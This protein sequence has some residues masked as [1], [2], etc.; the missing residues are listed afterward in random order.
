MAEKKYWRC[1]ICGDHHWGVNAPETCPTCGFGRDKAVEI[2][3]E[4][5]VK[6]VSE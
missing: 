5:F 3:K 2:S 4:E 1:T 6:E